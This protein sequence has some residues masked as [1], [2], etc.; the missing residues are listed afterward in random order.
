[1]TSS[2]GTCCVNTDGVVKLADFGIAKAAEQSDI[3]KVGSVLG[4]AAYLVARAGAGRAGRARL[5][6]VRARRRVLPADGRAAALRGGVADRPRAAAGVRAAAA[7]CRRPAATCRR[8]WPPPWPSAL[9][10]DPAQPL[11]GRAAEMED[12]LR[13]GLAGIAPTEDVDST[14]D[15]PPEDVDPRAVPTQPRAA[16]PAAPAAAGRRAARAPRRAAAARR[17]PRARRR[18]RRAEAPAS[19]SR[20]SSCSGHRGAIAYAQLG[21]TSKKQPTYNTDV[22]GSLDNAVGDFKSWSRTT[23]GS[24]LAGRLRSDGRAAKVWTVTVAQRDSRS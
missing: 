23:R 24:G 7:R 21:G 10:R 8:R 18:A 13:D 11:R 2:R 16:A 4:T 1:M 22:H 12:A 6:P 20:S 14:R 5:G 15:L 17:A 9:E 3:T 19:G